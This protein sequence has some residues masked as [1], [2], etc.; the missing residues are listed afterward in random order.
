MYKMND[1]T[2]CSARRIVRFFYIFLVINCV[3]AGVNELSQPSGLCCGAPERRSASLPGAGTTATNFPTNI[4]T[5]TYI[6][7][8]LLYLLRTILERVSNCNRFYTLVCNIHWFTLR[9]Y[10]I[11]WCIFLFSLLCCFWKI[12]VVCYLNHTDFIS[13]HR[14]DDLSEMM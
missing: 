8:I 12:G 1:Q 13:C 6:I 14:K 11:S 5:H 7:H 3:C 10:G 4:H 9:V 2:N